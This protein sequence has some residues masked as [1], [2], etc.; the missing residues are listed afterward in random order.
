MRES[1]IA[2]ISMYRKLGF[3]INNKL[4]HYYEMERW[5][6]PK[7]EVKSSSFI[8]THIFNLFN[9]LRNISQSLFKIFIQISL[10]CAPGILVS[11][12]NS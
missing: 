2:A 4:K 12:T 6:A 1:N 7:K 11:F 5:I 10:H 3:K 9:G 8:L